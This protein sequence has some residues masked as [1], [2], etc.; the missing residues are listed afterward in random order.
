MTAIEKDKTE[1]VTKIQQQQQKW[2][3]KRWKS[4]N[5]FMLLMLLIKNYLNT[6]KNKEGII[7][8]CDE[9]SDRNE[10]FFNQKYLNVKNIHLN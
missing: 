7:C 1:M 9:K 10:L 2:K 8:V 5:V 6:L 3:K 4:K